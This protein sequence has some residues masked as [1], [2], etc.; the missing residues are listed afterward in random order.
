MKKTYQSNQVEIPDKDICISIWDNVISKGTYLSLLSSVIGKKEGKL[1]S[2][3][4][5]WQS[6]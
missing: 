1:D 5:V 6:V 4:L 3:V 2:R